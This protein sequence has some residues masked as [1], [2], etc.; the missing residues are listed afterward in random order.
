MTISAALDTS[1][2]VGLLDIRDKW[3]PAALAVRD[4]L[5][6]S[7]AE[8]F[9]LDPVINE[10]IS[11]LARRLSEQRRIDQFIALL[12]RMALLSPADSII[13]ISPKIAQLYPYVL[14]LVRQHKGKLNFHDALISLACKEL[15]IEYIV[16]FDRDFDDIEW[17][18]RIAVPND[19][20]L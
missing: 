13:W 9:Y 15:N 5:K 12:D 2:L 16:S 1:F 7:D 4:V 20:P 6:A 3:H 11:V 18:T 19:V 14:D 10:V 17:L 8:L